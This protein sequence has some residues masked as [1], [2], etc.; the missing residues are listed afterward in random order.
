MS[1]IRRG[2]V[3]VARVMAALVFVYAGWIKI[4]AP[5]TFADSIAAFQL[6]PAWTSNLLALGLPPY[7]MIVGGWLLSGW[8]TRSA[9]FCALA[10]CGG[11]LLALF[12]ALIRGLPV[13]CGCFGEA[14]SSLA[15]T[16]RLWLAIGRD[17]LLGGAVALV[18]LA[19]RRKG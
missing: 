12:S 19:A 10:A 16:P 2:A 8:K 1:V 14:H 11:F 9:A 17:V 15:P 6:L 13:E 7:E 5:Q 4:Q 18:Y 3:P